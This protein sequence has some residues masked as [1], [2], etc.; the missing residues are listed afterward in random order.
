[1]VMLEYEQS[2]EMKF[3]KFPRLV[4]K[5]DNAANY[6]QMKRAAMKQKQINSS[7]NKNP[8]GDNSSRMPSKRI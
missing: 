7:I 4:K 6:E 5:I 3:N 8:E 2:Y 1:M